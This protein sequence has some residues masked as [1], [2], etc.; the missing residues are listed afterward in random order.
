MSTT[1]SVTKFLWFFL[2]TSHGLI[3]DF[4]TP[5]LALLDWRVSGGGR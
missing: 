4:L 3:A 1:E 2:P 5:P